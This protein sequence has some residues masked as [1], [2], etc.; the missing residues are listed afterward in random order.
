MIDPLSHL[1]CSAPPGRNLHHLQPRDVWRQELLGHHQPA[2][3]LHP[4][5]R[6]LRE[7]TRSRRQRERVRINAVD[8]SSPPSS[9]RFFSLS[10][11]LK[12]CV[13]PLQRATAE[14][15][16]GFFFFSN[17]NSFFKKCHCSVMLAGYANANVTT[18]LTPTFQLPATKCYLLF[19]SQMWSKCD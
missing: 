8:S 19:F 2:A 16:S 18:I 5:G 14:W 13:V 1:G 3:V 4:G 12:P 17:V 11:P 6:R 9:L 15:A 7:E 10:S